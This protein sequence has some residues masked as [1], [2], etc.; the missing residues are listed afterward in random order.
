MFFGGVAE[1]IST[2]LLYHFEYAKT[3]LVNDIEKVGKKKQFNGILDVYKKTYVSDGVAGLYRGF[4]ISVSRI[5]VYRAFHFGIYD[6]FKPSVER[7]FNE[8]IFFTFLLGWV[9]GVSAGFAAYP[10]DTISRRM[11]MTSCEKIKYKNFM[12]CFKS[13]SKR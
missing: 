2:L 13:I 9:S 3:R 7:I 6:T 1:L 5:F 11:M 10:L 12:E 4:T 8:N